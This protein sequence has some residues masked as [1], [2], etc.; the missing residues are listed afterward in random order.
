MLFRSLLADTRHEAPR[1]ITLATVTPPG[2]VLLC[3][4]ALVT[5]YVALWSL[6]V[7]VALTLA[8]GLSW[9]ALWALVAAWAA[10]LVTLAA[11]A[12]ALTALAGATL[13]ALAS[14][15]LVA[16]QSLRVSVAHGL[17]FALDAHFW[18]FSPLAVVVTLAALCIAVFV[19]GRPRLLNLPDAAGTRAW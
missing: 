15:A 5:V 18:T 10:P 13:S 17:A 2:V 4:A 6:V 16:L 11:L 9:A 7:S 19:A 1:E 3:R 8:T 12:L 14:A